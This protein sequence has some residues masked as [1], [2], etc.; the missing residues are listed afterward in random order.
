[1][2]YSQPLFGP[3]ATDLIYITIV[4]FGIWAVITIFPSLAGDISKRVGA[5]ITIFKRNFNKV[6]SKIKFFRR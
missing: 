1:M 4:I 3:G 6:S 2:S 5:E